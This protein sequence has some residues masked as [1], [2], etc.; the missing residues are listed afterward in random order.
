MA[1]RELLESIFP[2][3]QQA[4]TASTDA[5]SAEKFI[6]TDWK[7]AKGFVRLSPLLSSPTYRSYALEGFILSAGSLSTWTSQSAFSA[8]I[9]HLKPMRKDQVAMGRFLG[10]MLGLMRRS[11]DPTPVVRTLRMLMSDRVFAVLEGEPDSCEP[12]AAF[13]EGIVDVGILDIEGSIPYPT[14]SPFIAD[15]PLSRPCEHQMPGPL[16][17]R[18]PA[19]TQHH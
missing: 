6:E 12:L 17:R 9:Q 18:L 19:P 5:G 16:R 14:N 13:V 10:D 2:P 4:P 8:L 11:K 1:E 15:S 7:H 3:P